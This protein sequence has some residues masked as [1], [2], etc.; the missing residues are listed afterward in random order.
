MGSSRGGTHCRITQFGTFSLGL[1][2][3]TLTLN[4]DEDWKW[5]ALDL[6]C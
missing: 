4:A 3:L 5:H 1:G 2:K 6:K